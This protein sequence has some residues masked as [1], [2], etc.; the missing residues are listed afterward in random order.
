MKRH[1]SIFLLSSIIFFGLT[2]PV[3]ADWVTATVAA[4]SS[5]RA[6][7]V[8]PV[9]NKIYVTC[10][11]SANVMVIDGSTND[12]A[13]VTVG[14]DP[15]A[16][17]VNPV[18][19]KVYVANYGS[20][21]VTV[22]DGVTNGTT[23]ITVGS[24][25]WPMAVNPVT[26]KVYVA[27][28]NGMNVTVIDGYTN[29][30]ATISVGD[31]PWALAVNPVTNKVYVAN[32]ISNNVTV[33]DGA[34]N[35]T[36]TV[37]AGTHP[38]AVAVNP[39]TNKIY[40]ANMGSNTVT[41]IDGSSNDTA[42]VTTSSGPRAVAVNPATNKIY[43]A[44]NVSVTVIDGATNG[45]ATVA[46][47]SGPVALAL[48]PVTNKVYVANSISN[49]VTVIDGATNGTTTV[50]V[51]TGPYAVA[52]NP[53]T[54]KAYVANNI[55]NTVTVIDGSSNSTATVAAGSN[56][57]VLAVNPVTNQAYVTN[58]G[59]SSVTVI[60]GSTNGTATVGAGSGPVA[61][62]VNPAINKIYVAN[63]NSD[64]VT[65]IDGSTNGTATV[66]AGDYPWAVAVNPVTNKVY[67]A[68]NGSANVT[69]I[70]GATNGTAMVAAGS[71]PGAVAVNPVTN[72][73][74]VAN[75]GSD[76]VT[77]IDGAT[78]STATVAVGD[79]PWALAVNPVT[80]KVY[81]ANYSSNSVT[82]IDGSSNGTA[83]VA[84][85]SGPVALA[86]NPVTNKVYVANYDGNS[87]MV[88]T[89]APAYDTGV[90]AV[91]TF[92]DSNLVY[93]P[94]PALTGKA[95]NRWPSDKTA[96]MGAL[97]DM[98]T[99]QQVWNWA[100]G[101]YD[102]TSSD[103]IGWNYGWGEDSLLWGENFV[104]ILPLEMQAAGCNNLGLGTPFAGNMLTVPIYYMDNVAPSTVSLVSPADG[105]ITR[106]SLFTF[107]WH[108]AT[109]N[110]GMGSYQFSLWASDTV[111][112]VVSDTSI[113]LKLSIA[114]S[115]FQ[116]QAK[117]ID[118]AGNK[119]PF[120]ETW[121]L[122]NDWQP[123]SQVSLIS[124]ANGSGSTGDNL[125]TFIWHQATDN[126]AM[127]WYRF[128]A[129]D[130][131]LF[132]VALDTTVNDTIADLVLPYKNRVYRWHVQA[133][134]SCQNVGAWSAYWLVEVDTLTPGVPVPVAPYLNS[135]LSDNS[136]VY[137]W[138]PVS[139]L[140][141]EAKSTEVCYVL[142]ADT[143]SGFASPFLITDT[144]ALTIDTMAL[145]E[146]RYYWRVMAY[147]AAGNYGTYSSSRWFG[148]D[149]TAPLIQYLT[150][151]PDDESAPY[152]PYAI[153][154]SVYELSGIKTARLF[155]Q[156]NGG[157]WD[158][159]AMFFA[160]D[161]LRDSIPELAPTA[162]E[163]LSVNYY[164]K[165][166][167]LLGHVNTS[168]V[169]NFE[170]TGPSGVSGRPGCSVP[171]I[172]AL[173]NA[174][175]NPSK[176]QTTFTYQLPKSSDVRL[177][178]YNVAGQMIRVFDE[179]IKTAGYHQIRWNGDAA[180]G[181]YIYRLKAGNFVSTKKMMIVR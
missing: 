35:D 48:N 99:G 126:C 127:G 129:I 150:T 135:W 46:A 88:I 147:D 60:D 18:T 80:N 121:A 17:A 113:S 15:R 21:T 125:F 11:G 179:G 181:V 57:L 10:S 81:V 154:G 114:D 175:P 33:I 177:E 163:T 170:I 115:L 162:N 92:P 173:D 89:E 24:G 34:T 38:Y 169:C 2:S 14:T 104:N 119:G 49:T 106:D 44:N 79:Y 111:D 73:V 155:W 87:V 31:N 5:P 174:C 16:V 84:A 143:S 120:S 82:V 63:A 25:P 176:G 100:A 85:G 83:T 58:E 50:T 144:T 161:S 74:Y 7:A 51:G 32:Y 22:I 130:D 110:Y 145:P 140:G 134:D 105:A 40:V 141:K 56:P 8:N 12:T 164:I 136:V 45:T 75:I 165:V 9:T 1:I 168:S 23:T 76:N 72:K 55:S 52:V 6:V 19:N 64:N 108:R 133:I 95:V 67:V 116:W 65:V 118:A 77:V 94:Q 124:P 122:R 139:K 54:N 132:L 142:Q 61:L 37:T 138:S 59:S 91:M 62:A 90:R 149:T 131:S 103:S 86:V 98:M 166:A 137:S 156:V 167:D 27:N 4:G 117:A 71:Y 96:M 13:T 159:T 68:N 29:A 178:I 148:V 112:T 172:Y 20:G 153:A 43:V 180:S 151:V 160:S 70:D 146:G 123:P 30:T 107:H 101:P 69:V 152:G 93:Q 97:D 36:A 47:G 158:S 128:Q 78:N 26:N 157:A 3:W 28:V 171:I 39:A 109:D 66:A 41:V 102:S 53:V 42:T